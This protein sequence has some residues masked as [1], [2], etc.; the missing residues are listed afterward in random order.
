MTDALPEKVKAALEKARAQNRR[1][2]LMTCGVSGSG[3]STLSR[4]IISQYPNFV[5][6]SIDDYIEKHYGEP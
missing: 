1:T 4:N 2:V 3:K 5:K 6:L